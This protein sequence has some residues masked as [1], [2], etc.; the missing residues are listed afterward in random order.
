MYENY[1]NKSLKINNFSVYQINSFLEFPVLL[2]KS[3]NEFL[4]HELLKKGYDIRRTWYVNSLRYLKSNF[5]LEKFSN[6][7]NLH[8]K[9]LSLPTHDNISEKDIVNICEVI[10]FHESN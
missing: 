9:V 7:E 3:N 10:N 8:E 1:L 5:V 6:C 4:S 2:K